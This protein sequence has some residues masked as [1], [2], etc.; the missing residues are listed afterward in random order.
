MR[1][2]EGTTRRVF[3]SCVIRRIIPG[4]YHRSPLLL[5]GASSLSSIVSIGS[6]DELPRFE[7]KLLIS[8]FSRLIHSRLRS[9]W[10]DPT[11]PYWVPYLTVPYRPLPRPSR[12]WTNV[13]SPSHHSQATTKATPNAGELAITSLSLNRNHPNNEH[14]HLAFILLRLSRVFS[15]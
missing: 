11:P 14:E 7:T 12:P 4:R 8:T 15:R 1:E 6:S 13:I 5:H 10:S 2:S 3:S 9:V